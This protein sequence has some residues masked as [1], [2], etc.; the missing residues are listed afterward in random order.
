MRIELQIRPNDPSIAPLRDAWRNAAR[1]HDGR[2]DALARSARERYDQ[3]AGN[4]LPSV[5]REPLSLVPSMARMLSDAHWDIESA[6]REHVVGALA[7]FVDPNDLIPDDEGHFGFLDD[8]MVIKI[9]L[10]EA[11]H[12]WFAWCDFSDYMEAHPEEIGIDRETWMQRRRDR[13]E[14]SL[15]R[16]VDPGHSAS[17]TRPVQLRSD[18]GRY[19]PNFDSPPRFGV[20]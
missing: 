6:A 5:V 8:A 16:R 13:F 20:R 11:Q 7:Y 15:R 3:I 14:A 4:D 1:R 12:E 10:A 18:A 9:A 17:S 19:A 2:H